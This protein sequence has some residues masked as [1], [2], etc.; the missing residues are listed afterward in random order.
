MQKNRWKSWFAVVL[1]ALVAL[2]GAG[3]IALCIGSDGHIDL[4]ANTE[5]LRQNT[6]IKAGDGA[7]YSSQI[8]NNTQS[9]GC[10]VDIPLGSDNKI[11]SP[12][13]SITSVVNRLSIEQATVID[14]YTD[15]LRFIRIFPQSSEPLA[16]SFHWPITSVVMLI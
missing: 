10:C 7:I 15:K 3:A 12:M 6:C 2:D 16:Y 14:N 11:P 1:M 5:Q 8:M 4:K 13:S 9:A